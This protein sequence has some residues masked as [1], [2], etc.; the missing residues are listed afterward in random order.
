MSEQ[1][2]NRIGGRRWRKLTMG[3]FP[4]PGPTKL[5]KRREDGKCAILVLAKPVRHA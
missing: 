5:G 2:E 3:E 4:P 1:G